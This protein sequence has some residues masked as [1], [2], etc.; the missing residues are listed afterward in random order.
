MLLSLRERERE[1]AYENKRQLFSMRTQRALVN[2]PA[3]RFGREGNPRRTDD[4][5]NAAARRTAVKRIR[6]DTEPFRSR[7]DERREEKRA[8][9]RASERSA[10]RRGR[11]NARTRLA[12]G[13]RAPKHART[14]ATTCPL[15]YPRRESGNARRNEEHGAK[16]QR[17][18][19]T[20]ASTAAKLRRYNDTMERGGGGRDEV[21]EKA[22]PAKLGAPAGRPVERVRERMLR[23][24]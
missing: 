17:S 16:V 1:R 20:C 6:D 23:R 24:L 5:E 4:A 19:S 15:N 8:R 7:V 11:K 10:H 21:S 18:L 3:S 9:E 2:A 14:P 12:L 13:L 22:S